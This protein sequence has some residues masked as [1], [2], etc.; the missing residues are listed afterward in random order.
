MS[1]KANPTRIGGFVLASLMLAVLGV[2]LF[3][4]GRFFE[5]TEPFVCYFDG[6]INGLAVG[7]NVK[8]KGV[9]IGSVSEILL[10]FDESDDSASVRIPVVIRIDESKIEKGADRPVDLS[11]PKV[12]QSLISRGLRASL[13]SESL[14]TGL[15]YVNLDFYPDAP[16]IRLAEAGDMMVIP[17]LPSTLEA[18]QEVMGRVVRELDQVDFKEVFLSVEETIESIHEMLT[19][20][21]IPSTMESLADTMESL[22]KLSHTLNEKIGPFS[23]A[24]EGTALQADTTLQELTDVIASVGV[25]LDPESPLAFQVGQT[26]RQ[27]SGASDSVRELAN[28][29]EEHPSALLYG[30]GGEPEE[31]NP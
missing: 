23:E 6:S 21:E 12:L 4:S 22:R 2:A 31:E 27:V 9:P 13:Q 29:L 11:D 16:P 8:F 26:L 15:L 30:R 1:K 19:S 18:V 5:R 7:S 25:L 17:T 10:R 14:V 28:F 24:V 20:P 3:G